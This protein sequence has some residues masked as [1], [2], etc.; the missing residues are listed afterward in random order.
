MFLIACVVVFGLMLIFAPDELRTGQHRAL[1]VTYSVLVGFLAYFSAGS[2]RLIAESELSTMA[3]VGICLG[4]AFVAAALVFA[5]WEFGA[6]PVT[7]S[8]G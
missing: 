8:G 7:R 2:T 1:G 5:V 3:K 6:S 4:I